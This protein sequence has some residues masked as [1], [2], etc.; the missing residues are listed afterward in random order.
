MKKVKN[1]KVEM[2]QW[3]KISATMRRVNCRSDRR[4]VRRERA[5]T[6]VRR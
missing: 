3:I 6:I 5:H 2:V 1:R 4:L